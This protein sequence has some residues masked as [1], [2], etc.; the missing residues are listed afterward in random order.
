MGSPPLKVIKNM[1]L[2]TIRI[3]DLRIRL[4]LHRVSELLR[5]PVLLLFLPIQA[6]CPK[7]TKDCEQSSGHDDKL[8][9]QNIVLASVLV[10]DAVCRRI[11]TAEEMGEEEERDGGAEAALEDDVG[12]GPLKILGE[13]VSEGCTE[14]TLEGGPSETH[15]SEGRD[16][17]G[18]RISSGVNHE[19]SCERS[20]RDGSSDEDGALSSVLGDP[21]GDE[22]HDGG[23][24]G[25]DGSEN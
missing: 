15:E 13:V 6:T 3:C 20:E 10:F 21:S 9:D 16:E 5:E 2:Q 12:E 22:G 18:P 25:G 11:V 4:T 14:G 23:D 7:V 19:H 17:E 1:F 8:Q 24:S